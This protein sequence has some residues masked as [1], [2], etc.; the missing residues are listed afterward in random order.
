[1][2]QIRYMGDDR[3]SE[4]GVCIHCGEGLDESDTSAD[5]VPSKGLLDKPYPTQLPTVTIHAKCNN[6][7]SADEL[8]LVTLLGCIL[9]GS[10]EI[11]G[12]T[13]PRTARRLQKN[14]VLREQIAAS[15]RDKR[16][17]SGDSRPWWSVDT[18]RIAS[19]IEKNARGHVLFECAEPVLDAPS[20]ITFDALE[21]LD[22]N[23]KT[24]FENSQ[25]ELG[26]VL[27]SEVGSRSMVRQLTGADVVDGW[28]VVQAGVYRF[29]VVET[30][31]TIR[32][33]TVIREYL[34]TDT[35]WLRA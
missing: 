3:L 17:S 22:D 5:H 30:A 35:C 20:Y 25:D 19:V 15:R 4:C 26:V 14:P 33:K 7:F 6:A 16:D 27:F 31:S 32:V 21:S 9:A 13:D 1:M 2:E 24:R 34:V 10:A 8:Y 23:Q 12:Q 11:D 29:A 18:P 28:V